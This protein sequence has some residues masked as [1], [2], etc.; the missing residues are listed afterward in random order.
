M[1]LIV[2]PPPSV[3]GRASFPSYSLASHWCLYSLYSFLF[4]VRPTSL[5]H[6]VSTIEQNG[7]RGSLTA[8]AGTRVIGH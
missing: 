6:T 2:I 7:I 3:V 4:Q 8:G 1:R 5:S